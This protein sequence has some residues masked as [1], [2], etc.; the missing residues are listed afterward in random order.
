VNTFWGSR[1]STHS[2]VGRLRARLLAVAVLFITGGC[3]SGPAAPA[4]SGASQPAAPS[5]PKSITIAFPHDPNS[6]GG[7]LAGGSQSAVV[8]SRYF[9]EFPNAYLT[10]YNQQDETTAWLV[11]Q[12]PS[13]DDGTWTV[14]DN[15]GMEVT[16]KLRPGTKWHD[17]ADLTSD[18]LAYSWDIQH[19]P[20]TQIGNSSIARLV[21]EVRTPDPLT[22][23]FVWPQISQLGNLAGVREFDVLPRHVLESVERSALIDHPYFQDPEVFVGAGPY[24]PTTWDRGRS[25]TLEA[26]DKY[27]LGRPKIDR[28]MFLT[29]SDYQTALVNVLSGRVD[30]GYWAVSYEGARIIQQE[31]ANNGGGTV[32]MHANNARFFFPQL[33][34]EYATPTDLTAV[35][36]RQAIMHAMD[37]H[38]LAETAAAGA[39]PV[40]NSTTYLDSALG[41]AVEA[42]APQYAFDPA[43]ATALL[44]EA[45]WRPGA[46]GILTKGGDRFQ[47]PYRL[48]STNTTGDQVLLFPVLQQQLRRVGIDLFTVMTA[49]GDQQADAAFPGLVFSGLP[50]NQTGFLTRFAT[51]NIAGPQNR[52]TGNN[53]DGYSNPVFDQLVQRVDVTL[54]REE[55]IQLWAEANRVIVEDVGFMPLYNYPYPYIV[56]K[57]VVGALPGNPI[58]PPAYFVH[59]WDVQ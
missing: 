27:F 37:R 32:E 12:V 29:I 10:T 36:V 55:R 3:A 41:R 20:I 47:L 18:D 6:L 49:Q 8:P 43:R 14:L 48:A 33:R 25:V 30:V 1:P 50:A 52:W 23:V 39:A 5:A 44:A 22:A 16:W 28:V 34:P 45:G 26:F 54:R 31:W 38:E 13:L 58:N 57:N 46:D 7:S 35:R 2:A 17:G 40:V 51:A 15:G 9:R 24:R 56:R 42:K 4:S 53:R 59:T 11:T 19:D 21:S